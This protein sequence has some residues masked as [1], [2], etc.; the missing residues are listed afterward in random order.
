MKLNDLPWQDADW[1]DILSRVRAGRLPHGLL[2]AGPA[3]I[4]KVA[5]GERLAH[6]LL[7]ESAE[8]ADHR[9]LR[10]PGLSR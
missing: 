9:G 6:W 7:C 3:G 1:C 4:G 5:F 2:L 10:V 8:R